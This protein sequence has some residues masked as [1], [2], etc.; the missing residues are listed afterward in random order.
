MEDEHD[1]EAWLCTSLSR[2][3]AASFCRRGWALPC[4]PG[5]GCCGVLRMVLDG[6]RDAAA[7][8]VAAR[9]TGLTLRNA[10]SMMEN[11]GMGLLRLAPDDSRGR[12]GVSSWAVSLAVAVAVVVA[13]VVAALRRSDPCSTGQ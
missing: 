10:V 3:S 11:G 2:F 12:A 6:E 13:D 5:G 7:G 4:R 8:V 1:D 9:K